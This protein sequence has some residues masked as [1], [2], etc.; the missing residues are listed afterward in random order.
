MLSVR[1][2]GLLMLAIFSLAAAAPPATAQ[3]RLDFR[4][5]D[6]AILSADHERI[7]GHARYTIEQAGG[8]E[9]VKGEN[10]YLDG[11]YDLEVDRLQPRSGGQPPL[12][13]FF[14]H[15]FY[16]AGGALQLEAQMD[17]ASGSAS[18]AK[19]D[20][21]SSAT[22]RA[23]LD[24]PEDTYA[25]ASVLIPLEAGL[26]QGLDHIT[27]HAFNCVPAPKVIDVEARLANARTRWALYPG[28]LVRVVVRPDFGWLNLLVAPFV[29]KIYAWFDPGSDWTYVGGQLQRFYRGPTIVLVKRLPDHKLD[30][31]AAPPGPGH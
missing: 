21:G 9:I 18:C 10:R 31:A 29:P 30:S 13:L 1:V 23:T 22:R 24:L 26:R 28:E 15:S 3:T 25:G 17:R 27:L 16:Q 8:V 7:I 12:L 11:E 14:R 2:P 4:P 19:P 5:A 6:L 20:D